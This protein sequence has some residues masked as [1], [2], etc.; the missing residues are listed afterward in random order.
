MGIEE[1][2]GIRIPST[3]R[4]FIHRTVGIHVNLIN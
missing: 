4:C 2:M 1:Q 3:A